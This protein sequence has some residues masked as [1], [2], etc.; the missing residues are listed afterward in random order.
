MSRFEVRL[1]EWGDDSDYHRKYCNMVQT[2]KDLEFL[3]EMAEKD[4]ESAKL[5]AQKQYFQKKIELYKEELK[6]KIALS[7]PQ[8]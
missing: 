7:I 3:I 1:H 6:R 4:K 2:K 5:L 8:K